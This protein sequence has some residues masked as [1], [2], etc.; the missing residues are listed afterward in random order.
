M[1]SIPLTLAVAGIA[2]LG[3]SF[4]GAYAAQQSSERPFGGPPPP[5]NRDDDPPKTRSLKT[6]GSTCRVSGTSCKL[7]NPQDVGSSC[8]CPGDGGKGKVQ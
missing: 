4:D 3:L 2:L 5:R 1:R 6:K 7:S 8:S